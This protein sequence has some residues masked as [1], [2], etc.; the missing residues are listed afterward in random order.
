M[1][2]RQPSLHIYISKIQKM[3]RLDDDVMSVVVVELPEAPKD[4]PQKC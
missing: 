2:E 4:D 3:A 1:L